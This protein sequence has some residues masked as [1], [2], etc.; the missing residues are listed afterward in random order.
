MYAF[1]FPDANI[2]IQDKGDNAVYTFRFFRE[3]CANSIGEVL[4]TLSVRTEDETG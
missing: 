1:H 3:I 4:Q 2:V